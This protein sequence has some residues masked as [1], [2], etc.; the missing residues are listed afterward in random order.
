[1]ENVSK[2]NN[3]EGVTQKSMCMLSGVFHSTIYRLILDK[4]IMPIDGK[5]KKIQDIQYLIQ[6]KF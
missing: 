1:M 3:V 6:E 4:K 2:L 5:Q